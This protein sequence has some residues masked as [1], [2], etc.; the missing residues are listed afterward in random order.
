MK[1]VPYITED[2]KDLVQETLEYVLLNMYIQAAELPS[3]SA[4]CT[5]ASGN[6]QEEKGN[7]N[8]SVQVAHS[9]CLKKT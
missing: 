9:P 2:Y 3:P 5:T 7:K 1:I 4:S 8:I 6:E